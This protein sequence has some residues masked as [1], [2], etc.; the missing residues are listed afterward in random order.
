[1]P[2]APPALRSTAWPLSL[3]AL[4]LVAYASFYPLSGWAWPPGSVFQ[5]T[6]P[7][8]PR[9]YAD[10]IAANV[11]GYLPLGAI[12]CLAHLRSGR[13]PWLAALMAL[14]TCTA[15]S[16]GIELVQHFLPS[17]VPSVMD[18]M[19]N[20]LGAAWGVLVALTLHALGWVDTWH[21][22]RV[23]W[24]GRQMGGGLALLLLWPV[25]LLTPL[26]TPLGEGRL[27]PRLLALLTEAAAGSVWQPWVV[28]VTPPA[29]W[30]LQARVVQGLSADVLELATVL[31]G[32]LLPMC[33]AAAISGHRRFRIT[34]FAAI[35]LAAFAVTSL[36]S[37]LNFG[38]GHA[39]A[40]LTLTGTWGLL[41]AALAGW[42]LLA[43]RPRWA[44]LLGLMA[45]LLLLLLVHLAPADPYFAQTLQSWE[46]GLFI[47]FH[48]LT[49]WIGQLWPWCAA[50]WL[51]NRLMTRPRHGAL[52]RPPTASP[53]TT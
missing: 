47:R 30:Q 33:M 36:S 15:W 46:R 3:V 53:P 29:W 26:P 34:V 25:G 16:Y 42:G 7:K 5:W 14:L 38:L 11:L 52:E 40:W 6:L 48:G 8:L 39:L 31:A 41:L 50:A 27:L 32:A 19:L 18:W 9:E 4:A 13:R 22:W 28:P 24:L 43:L 23:N 10:D 45:A 12:W 17:R 49:A 2:D 37:A 35:V 44:A 20:S 51:L 21:R 1:M